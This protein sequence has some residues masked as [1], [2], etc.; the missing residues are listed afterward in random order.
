VKDPV[1]WMITMIKDG[2]LN[3]QAGVG[4]GAAALFGEKAAAH[5]NIVVCSLP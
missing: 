1:K 4:P 3:R 2:A 5:N